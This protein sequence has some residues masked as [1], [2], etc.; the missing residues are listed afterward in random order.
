[1]K[2]YRCQHTMS[3]RDSTCSSCGQT[4]FTT[5]S[6]T[7]LSY[8]RRLDGCLPDEPRVSD[9]RATANLTTMPIKVDLRPECSRV[10]DQ[11]QLGSCVANAIVGAYEHQ[12]KRDGKPQ[13][14]FS[15]LFVYYNARRVLGATDMDNGSTISAGMAAMLAFGAPKESSWPYRVET[16]ST[17]PSPEVYQEA[18]KNVPVEYARV[19]GLEGVQGAIARRQPVVV[20]A[21]IPERIYQAAGETGVAPNPKKSEVDAIRSRNGRHALLIIAFDRN[22][23]TVTAR[24]SWGEDWGDKGYFTMS[25][26]TFTEVLAPNTTWILGRL[27]ANDFSIVRPPGTMSTSEAAIPRVDGGVK[28]MAE[29]MRNEIRDGLNKDIADSFKDIRERM[30]PPQQGQ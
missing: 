26:D 20:A 15:R 19:D 4:M 12:M 29:K 5:F 21:D 22:A 30:K 27:D 25:F 18:L 13:T 2:C 8:G 1:M 7:S 28:D 24:N 9:Y 10:E 6:R 14:D 23:G 3:H 17:A 16:F 11:G